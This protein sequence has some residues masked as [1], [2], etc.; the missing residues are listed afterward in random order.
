MSKTYRWGVLAPGRIA[1]KFVQEIR[2]LPNVRLWAVGSR[3]LERATAFAREH[4]FER[5]Y[6]SYEALVSDPELDV[7]YVASPH[8]FHTEHTLLCLKHG[9]AVLCEKAFGMNAEEVRSMVDAA[10]TGNRFLMEA[11]TTPHQPSYRDAYAIVQSGELGKILHINGWFGFNRSPYDPEGRLLNPLLGG[12]ALLDIGLYP[13]FDA[14]W[15]LG[16]PLQ[17]QASADLTES[18]IDRSITVNMTFGD[19]ATASI[20]ASFYSAIGV[21]TY[22]FC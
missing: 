21:G 22:I 2:E 19:H 10:V 5:A 12:G 4:Q 11:L 1:A 3:D 20:F 15:F 6:G 7:V 9:K 8:V 14:L 16:D 17:I 13:L 18:H